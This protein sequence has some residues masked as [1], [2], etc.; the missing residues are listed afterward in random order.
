MCEGQLAA[1]ASCFKKETK[2][3]T[4]LDLNP[5]RQKFFKMDAADFWLEMQLLHYVIC[6]FS[7]VSNRSKWDEMELKLLKELHTI[8]L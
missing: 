6:P 4:L 2:E 3:G 8:V 1:V 7:V 5:F